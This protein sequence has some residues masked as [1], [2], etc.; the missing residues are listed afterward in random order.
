MAFITQR[1]TVRDEVY[2][3]KMKN[4][5]RELKTM[6][7]VNQISQST[8]LL[9]KKKDMCE[10]EDAMNFM[11]GE[12]RDR[13]SVCSTRQAEF[14]KRQTE[15][16]D[17]V[18]KFEK[19]IQENDSKLAR[20]ETKL[21]Q[22]RKVLQQKIAEFQAR[23]EEERK[24]KQDRQNLIKELGSLRKY[25]DYLE[26]IVEMTT[27]EVHSYEEIWDVIN[28]HVTLKST[29]N[30]LIAQVHDGE[31]KNDANRTELV[32]VKT[33]HSNRMLMQNSLI[34]SHQQHLEEK[35][36]CYRYSTE[37][38]EREDA[39][40]K[41]DRREMGQVNLAVK[42]LYSRCCATLQ[43]RIAPVA[44]VEGTKPG[45]RLKHLEQCLQQICERIIDLSEIHKANTENRLLEDKTMDMAGTVLESVDT[46]PSRRV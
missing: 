23:Q 20:A 9:K 4:D 11:Q 13:M 5:I 25:R 19:F 32:S 15:L 21:K 36:Q 12:Y 35:R 46:T 28:R 41:K 3:A 17:Q 18:M 2:A 1:A 26:R 33:D 14:E 42:N 8:K 44:I 38:K 16:K 29:N 7:N 43:T 22:E 37:E 24:V 31:M 10:V 6:V 30:Q 40:R 39:A 45:D 34:H 27:S